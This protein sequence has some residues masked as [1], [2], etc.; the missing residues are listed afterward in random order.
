MRLPSALRTKKGVPPTPRKA[1]T[2]LLTPPGSTRWARP[3]SDSE[4]ESVMA[5]SGLRAL[6]VEGDE[7]PR[8]GVPAKGARLHH[9]PLRHREHDVG[10]VRIRGLSVEERV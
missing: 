2:G 6:P 7:V 8:A 10:R 5:R 9:P 3:K 1:R 4:R